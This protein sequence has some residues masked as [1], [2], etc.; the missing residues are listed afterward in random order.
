[1]RNKPATTGV[2]GQ[3]YPAQDG[4]IALVTEASHEGSWT[5][6]QGIKS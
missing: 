1:M 6:R 5:A 3:V 2:P 4:P